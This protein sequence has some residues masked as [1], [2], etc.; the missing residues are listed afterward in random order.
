MYQLTSTTA[1]ILVL[2]GTV[3]FV[4]FAMEGA[5][6]SAAPTSSQIEVVTSSAAVTVVSFYPIV[7]S[8][9][10]YFLK[11]YIGWSLIADSLEISSV[12]HVSSKQEMKSPRRSA[13]WLQRQALSS[14]SH[15]ASAAPAAMQSTEHAGSSSTRRSSQTSS[16]VA[17]VSVHRYILDSI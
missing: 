3:E 1:T 4:E 14:A 13:S 6:I 16:V 7:L 17:L 10:S 11:R 12:V 8:L 5:P 15:P 2:V 9:L